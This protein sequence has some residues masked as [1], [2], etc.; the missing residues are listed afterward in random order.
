MKLSTLNWI[1]FE[2]KNYSKG[3]NHLIF[4]QFLTLLEKNKT[5]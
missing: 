1:F 4:N 2:I 5:M 3:L